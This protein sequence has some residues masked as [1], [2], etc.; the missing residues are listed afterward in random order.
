VNGG[1]Y[2]KQPQGLV[3]ALRM[4]VIGAG[5]VKRY[6]IEAPTQEATD[7]LLDRQVQ[8]RLQGADANDSFTPGRHRAITIPARTGACPR[9]RDSGHF[10]D[11]ER[12]PPS[13]ASWSVPSSALRAENTCSC[14]K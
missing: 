14:R 7:S 11:D 5:S 13:L 12:N 2:A 10:E 8:Q 9:G 6:Y 1:D 4:V 3:T